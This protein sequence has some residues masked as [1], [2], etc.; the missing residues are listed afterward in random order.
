MKPR[1]M[2]RSQHE[3]VVARL[4]RLHA[5]ELAVVNEDRERLRKERNQFE[6]DRERVT[7]EAAATI[8]RLQRDLKGA[9]GGESK[10]ALRRRIRQLEKQYDD[11][12]GR[13]AGRIEDSS[14]WQP[15]YRD[16]KEA[17]S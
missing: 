4:N 11:A 9:S 14:R 7:A 5:E 1:F 2:P 10:E 16:P 8:A 13:P 3:A 12:V 17:A 6:Q 15:G